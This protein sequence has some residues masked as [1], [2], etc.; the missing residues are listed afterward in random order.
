LDEATA[1]AAGHRPC[2][3][4]QRARY[5]HFLDLWARTQPGA[6]RAHAADLDAALHVARW[7]AGRKVTYAA[8]LGDLPDGVMVALLEDEQPYLIGQGQLWR[9][10]F[11]GYRRGPQWPKTIAVRVLTPQPT[12][13]ILAAG[14]SVQV[15]PSLT[16]LLSSPLESGTDL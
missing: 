6:G 16:T 4:C 10:D 7:A 8:R 15:H 5:Q 14:Y 12:V 3:E 1:L 13:E 2:A 11:T 9:W